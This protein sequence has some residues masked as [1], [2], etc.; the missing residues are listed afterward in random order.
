MITRN[1]RIG[2]KRK[3]ADGFTKCEGFFEYEEKL[4]DKITR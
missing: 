2:V 3:D 1:R 4:V